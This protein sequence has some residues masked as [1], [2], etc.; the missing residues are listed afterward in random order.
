MVDAAKLAHFRSL[1]TAAPPSPRREAGKLERAVFIL[2][3]PR[4]GSTLL[5][6]MLAGHPSIF[7]P[8]ELELLGFTTMAERAEELSG[9]NS[10]WRE[11][12]VRAVMQLRGCEAEQAQEI[13]GD[14]EASGLGVGD[15]YGQLQEWLGGR[16]LVDK[17]PSYALDVEVLRRA[18]ELFEEPLYVH[19]VRDPRS[20]IGSFEEAKLDQVFFRPAHEL[21]RREL[22]ELIWVASEQNIEE[23]LGEVSSERQLVVRYEDLVREPE[24]EARRLSEFVGVEAVAGMMDPYAER[25][26]RMTDGIT[27][28]VEDGWRREVSRARGDRGEWSGEVAQPAGGRVMGRHLGGGSPVWIRAGSE[29]G[30]EWRATGRVAESGARRRAAAFICAAAA[31]VPGPAGAGQFFLQ[32]P[33]SSAPARYARPR[34]A[35]AELQGSHQA[36]RIAAHQVRE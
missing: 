12:L 9:R 20:M 7:A 17:T 18:E 23:F 14:W 27:S 29:R 21:T 28:V 22:A 3:A 30:E 36:T 26:E 4:S 13:A 16:M 11:G 5:R 24:R 35:G 8:P 6:V 10:F 34:R 33:G 2:S 19:L 1:I 31:M 25:G 32:H 15:C